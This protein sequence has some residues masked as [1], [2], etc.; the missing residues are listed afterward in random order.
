MNPSPLVPPETRPAASGAPRRAVYCD[1]DGTLSAT[2]IVGPLVFFQ[3]RL[4]PAPAYWLWLAALPPRGVF[5]LLLDK[6]SRAASNRAIYA[7]YAGWEAARVK[8]LAGACYDAYWR[9][10]LSREGLGRLARLKEE[11]AQLVLVTGSLD[12]LLEPL[13][14]ETGAELIAPKLEEVD[15]RFTG[16]LAGAPL[17]GEGKAAA[18]REHATRCQVDLS[19]SHSF[20]DALGDLAMLECVG[21]PA[22][23]NPGRRL[24]AEAARRGWTVEYWR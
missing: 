14:R 8:A 7:C 2:H 9:P 10:R 4:S 1:V 15:G 13:A 11:G 12:F 21:H 6:F 23:V 20:G 24:R 18:V 17:T 5:W 3:R 22:A 16:R 19:A